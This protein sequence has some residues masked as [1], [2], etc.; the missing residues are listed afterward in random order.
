MFLHLRQSVNLSLMSVKILLSGATGVIGEVIETLVKADDAL[1]VTG[2]ASRDRFFDNDTPGD[3]V[4]DFSHPEL[5]LKSLDFAVARGLPMVV[6]T[7]GLDPEQKE[8]IERAA[9]SIAICQASNFSLGVNLLID[10]ARRAA[11]ALDEDFD[12][13]IVETH[14]RR[15]LDAPSG[16]ALTLGRELAVARG[17]DPD[18]S[19]VFDRSARREPRRRGQIGYQALRGGE[20]AGE[21]TVHFLGDGERIELTHR[22]ADRSI[23]ARGALLAAKRIAGRGPGRVEFASLVLADPKGAG[24]V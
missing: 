7:T 12:I 4:I 18:E 22:S 13:E 17:V 6:G 16:T 5:C 20:V 14:H 8:R 11:G 24:K 9:E 10:L 1:E 19:A 21:H 23:F 3:V 2:R 15:K